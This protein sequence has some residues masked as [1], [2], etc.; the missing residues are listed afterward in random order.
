MDTH[1]TAARNY[2]FPWRENNRFEFLIDGTVFFPRMLGAIDSAREIILLEMYLIQSG[3]V[4]T[5]FIDALIKAAARGVK[6]YLLLDD[7]GATGLKQQDRDRLAQ[8]NIQIL[9]YNPLHSYSSLYNLYRIFWK[10]VDLGL[11]RDHRKLLLIDNNIAFTGGAGI[12]DDFDP[13]E[14]EKKWRETIVEIQGPVIKDWRQLFLAS[15]NRYAKSPLT[16]PDIA[17]VPF[18]NGQKGRVTCNVARHISGI[19]RSLNKQT[20]NARQRIWF[21]TAYFVPSWRLRRKLKRAARAGVDVRLLLP[22]PITDHPGVRYT[23]HRFYSRLLKNGV[24]IFEYQ[25][26]FLHSKTV[27]CDNW[28]TIGSSNFD[29]WNLRWNQEANQEIESQDIAATVE[30]IF[31]ADFKHS[32]EYTYKEWQQRHWI[33]RIPEWFWRQAEKLSIKFNQRRR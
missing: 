2:H 30:K 16:L 13:P 17:S 25:P 11:Y 33:T 4:A 14:P 8:Q 28:V 31:R 1:K 27:L 6:I 3:S 7:Y 15:W 23:S 20:Y 22:G 32:H 21:A 24:R 5:R 9:Y 12:T 10:R 26:R 19:Q 18:T 29:R